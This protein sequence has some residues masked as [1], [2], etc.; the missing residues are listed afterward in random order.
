MNKR[1]VSQWID[2]YCGEEAARLF[3]GERASG[4]HGK[5]YIKMNEPQKQ[6]LD[7]A[8]QLVRG[9][10]FKNRFPENWQG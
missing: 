2:D 4:N 10:L 1:T 5:F 8:L 6:K 7:A 9:I 3:R